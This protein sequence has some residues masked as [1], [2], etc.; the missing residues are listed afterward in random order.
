[1]ELGKFIKKHRVSK[2]WTITKL[3]EKTGISRPYLSQIESGLDS[4]PSEKK[5]RS[6]AEVLDIPL[7][8]ILSIAHQTNFTDEY[9]Q[10]ALDYDELYQNINTK[11]EE[12]TKKL[13]SLGDSLRETTTNE[14]D[15]RLQVKFHLQRSQIES[16]FYQIKYLLK[17]LSEK[18]KPQ[19]YSLTIENLITDLLAIGDDGQRYIK[20]QI[21]TYREFFTEADERS[22]LVAEDGARYSVCNKGKHK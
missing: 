9:I 2:G 16:E 14:A 11:Y 5:I 8:V 13:D 3:A 17:D 6:L 4:P 7:A 20:R 21:E 18:R 12:L 22:S 19:R 15:H 10:E 1:M